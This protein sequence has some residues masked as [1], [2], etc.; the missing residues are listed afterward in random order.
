MLTHVVWDAFTHKTGYFFMN[1]PSLQQRIY[2]MP[3]YKFMQHGSTCLVFLLLIYVVLWKHRDF[4]TKVNIVSAREKRKCWGWPMIKALVVF[5][6][7]ALLDPYFQILQIGSII[8]S[9]FTSVF[10]GLFIVSAIYET[11]EESS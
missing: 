6:M 3:I 7:H 4:Q 10:C 2:S 8:V 1:L 11:R 9:G 5:T